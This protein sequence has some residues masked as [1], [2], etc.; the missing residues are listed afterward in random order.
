MLGAFSAPPPKARYPQSASDIP[1]LSER[2]SKEQVY[3]TYMEHSVSVNDGRLVRAAGNGRMGQAAWASSWMGGLGIEV[4][5]TGRPGRHARDMG[6]S[7][8]G[9]A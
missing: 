9:R 4:D 6:V 5:C 7:W 2:P 3:V 8:T 1:I